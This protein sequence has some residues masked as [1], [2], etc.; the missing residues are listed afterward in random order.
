MNYIQ[1]YTTQP[2]TQTQMYKNKVCLYFGCFDPPHNGHRSVI[3]HI[4]NLNYFDNIMIIPTYDHCFKEDNVSDFTHRF[5]MTHLAFKDMDNI[6][7]STIEKELHEKKSYFEMNNIIIPLIE[8]EIHD[9][10][11]K[12]NYTSDTITFLQEQHPDTQ[13]SLTMGSDLFNTFLTQFNLDTYNIIDI[14]VVKRLGYPIDEDNIDELKRLYWI[15][16]F[17]VNYFKPIDNINSTDIKQKITNY[18]NVNQLL[19]IDVIEYIH[20]K[21]ELFDHYQSKL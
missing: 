6:I 15:N 5:E 12:K 4:S 3:E 19:S 7:V 18:M 9:N 2:N 14:Y 10:Y 1:T 8:T 11:S 13:F 16:V 20:S 21:P 17:I